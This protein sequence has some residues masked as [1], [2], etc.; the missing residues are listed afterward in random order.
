MVWS[1]MKGRV[2]FYKRFYPGKFRRDLRGIPL[3][4][5]KRVRLSWTC[6]TPQNLAYLVEKLDTHRDIYIQVVNQ[7]TRTPDRLFLDF[8]IEKDKIK[9]VWKNAL[10]RLQAGDVEGFD[11]NRER[12]KRMI[13]KRKIAKEPLEDVI[14]LRNYF[15]E[16]YDVDSIIFFSGGKGF[17]IYTPLKLVKYHDYNRALSYFARKLKDNA[18]PTLDLAVCKDA[19]VR[20][21]RAPYTMNM[22]TGLYMVPVDPDDDYPTI[23]NRALNPEP[24]PI[25]IPAPGRL[26][27]RIVEYDRIVKDLVEWEDE[28]RKQETRKYFNPG[29][30]MKGK[31]LRLIFKEELGP[32]T[33]DRGD[34]IMYRCPFP[35]HDDSNPS[36]SVM[37]GLWK[38]FGCNRRGFSWDDFIRQIKGGST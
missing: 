38:C 37:R 17:H 31:D 18:L 33:Y 20:L 19:L 9:N 14:S 34:Y 25:R 28:R 24:E 23:M 22:K 36:F 15:L 3:Q 32:P 10:E 7:E 29:K 4:D 5:G 27:D 8:D 1:K 11:E 35:D 2:R 12:I 21:G 26:Q 16:E 30:T 13:I 6:K